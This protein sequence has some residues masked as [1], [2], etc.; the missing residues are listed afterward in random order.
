LQA[1]QTR[2]SLR[3]ALVGE[4]VYAARLSASEL[5]A[6]GRRL[7][8]APQAHLHAA[9]APSNQAES[10][11]D[12]PR[13]RQTAQDAQT[14]PPQDQAASDG[15]FAFP[16]ER[17][18]PARRSED[19]GAERSSALAARAEPGRGAPQS[20]GAPAPSDRFLGDG[21]AVQA[22][23][24]ARVR[25]HASGTVDLLVFS[26]CDDGP[27]SECGVEWFAQEVAAA[28]RDTNRALLL[29]AMYESRRVDPQLLPA[30]GP[31]GHGPSPLLAQAAP[32]AEARSRPAG[33]ASP[34]V[35]A[36]SSKFAAPPLAAHSSGKVLPPVEISFVGW[37][38]FL[39][40]LETLL[41]CH[42]LFHVLF[43]SSCLWS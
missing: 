28:V 16:L 9:A 17:E 6:K 42:L 37:R 13:A 2:A 41:V 34:M 31:D 26:A 10:P 7:A 33:D 18:P 32:R 8:S 30:P 38:H 36:A 15:S 5:D 20:S 12:V 43:V 35:S 29:H 14:G 27:A 11:A 25:E 22:W 4:R 3:L 23:L 39:F 21:D 24:L 1:L 19:R 40:V